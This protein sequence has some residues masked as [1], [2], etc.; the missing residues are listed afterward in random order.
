MPYLLQD[1]RALAI[2]E[3]L[4]YCA[5]Y[6]KPVP[7]GGEA[8]VRVLG[9]GI[10]ATDIE[11]TKGYMGFRG[12]P[13]HEFVGIVESSGDKGLL[14]KRVVS[15]IN[16]GCGRCPVCRNGE[17]NHCHDRSVLGIFNK[18]GA[19]ADFLVLPQTNLHPIPQSVPDEEAVFVEPLA[20]AFEILEQVA[21][22]PA[23]RVCVLGDGRLGLLVAQVLNLTGCDLVIVGRHAEKLKV[24]SDRGIETRL[25]EAEEGDFDMVID[26]T[27]SP[28]GFESAVS[29]ARPRGTVVIKTTVAERGVFDLNR[30][31][32]DE[33]TV[34]G[35]RCGPFPPAIKALA[36]GSVD[37]RPLIAKQFPIEQ[38]VEAFEYAQKK[39][40]LKV[41]IKMV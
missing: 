11:I 39:G 6:P 30:V 24:L 14:G 38:G 31:V 26:C 4:R 16:I 8:L 15:E 9:A 41:I 7:E 33:I 13:G 1:M 32:I 29:L 22:G 25:K 28:Y 21:I 27:G 19:F 5:D 10:C 36:S 37:V 3:K 34:I 18:D 20:S 23:Q 12:V 17:A 2:D 35:S 40:V